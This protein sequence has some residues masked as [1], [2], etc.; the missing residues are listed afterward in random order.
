MK[1]LG[2]VKQISGM[3]IQRDKKNGKLWL[4][5]QKYVEK[6]LIRFSKNNLKPVQIPLASHFNISSGLC[7][8][9]EEEKGF[10]SPVSYAS[11]EFDVCNEMVI[12][13][14]VIVFFSRHI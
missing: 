3:E 10:M 4:T 7:P 5:Q 8:S 14:H 1:D 9:N 6:I 11:R 13:S 12:I 2:A